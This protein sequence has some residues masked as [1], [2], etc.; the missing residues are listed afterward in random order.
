MEAIE[1]APEKKH[2]KSKSKK[3]KRKGDRNEKSS[4]KKTRY[5]PY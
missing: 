3:E 2:S 5:E 1:A 4:G